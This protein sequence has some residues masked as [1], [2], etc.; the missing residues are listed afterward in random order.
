MNEF[1]SYEIITI[2]TIIGIV[3]TFISEI[4]YI[5]QIKKRAVVVSL[6]G[7]VVFFSSNVLGGGATIAMDGLYAG[8]IPITFSVFYIIMFYIVYMNRSHSGWNSFDSLLIIAAV[9]CG[10][11]WVVLEAPILALICGIGIDLIGYY[12]ILRK[13][14][15]YNGSENT[16]AWLCSSIAYTI[17]LFGLLTVEPLNLMTHSFLILN[18]IGCT[19]ITILNEYQRRIILKR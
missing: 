16:F 5:V 2:A 18:A 6:S 7:F 10:L 11:G 1:T 9:L 14:K 12:A 15:V 19:L 4:W 13:M 3:F 17:P 8:I